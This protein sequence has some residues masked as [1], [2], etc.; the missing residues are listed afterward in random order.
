MHDINKLRDQLSVQ[1]SVFDEPW[2]KSWHIVSDFKHISLNTAE[3]HIA[4]S[5]R[6]EKGGQIWDYFML[7]YNTHIDVIDWLPDNPTMNLGMQTT[8]KIDARAKHVNFMLT[9]IYFFLYACQ[10]HF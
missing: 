3:Q 6:M 2:G 1:H 4:A 10:V 7:L 9:M 5:L 8:P